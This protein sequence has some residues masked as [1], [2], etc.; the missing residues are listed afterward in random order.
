MHT[1][2]RNAVQ[3]PNPIEIKKEYKQKQNAFQKLFWYDKQ[4]FCSF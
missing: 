2:T 1:I 4:K 3:V